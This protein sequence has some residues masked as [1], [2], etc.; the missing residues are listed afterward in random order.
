MRKSDFY[1]CND[2]VHT[3][4]GLLCDIAD[5]CVCDASFS[6][7]FVTIS[8]IKCFLAILCSVILRI[9]PVSLLCNFFILYR[10]FLN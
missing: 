6:E 10:Y 4:Y 1:V 9:V 7:S 3:S 8:V 2:V 5:L